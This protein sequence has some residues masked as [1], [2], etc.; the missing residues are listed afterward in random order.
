MLY[1]TT[2]NNSDT[3]T[4]QRVLSTRRA[5]DGGVFIPFHLP[6]LSQAE[7]SRMCKI[8]F[9][10]RVA[11]IL[12]L[13]FG[14]HLTGYD[15]DLAVGKRSV[16]LHQLGQRLFSAECWHNTQW[17]FL[18]MV[19]AMIPLLYSGKE[20]DAEVAGWLDTGIRMAILF[21]IFGELIRE[22]LVSGDKPAD[23]SMVSGSFSGPMAAWYARGMGLPIGNIVC[24]CNENGALWDFI[25]HGQLRTDGIAARTAVP[26][27][28]ILIPEGLEQLIALYG[29]PQEVHQYVECLHTGRTYYV[30]DGLL[31]RMRKGI[32]VTVSSEQRILSTVSSIFSAHNYLLSLPSAL[33]YAGLQ[34]YRART[35]ESRLALILTDSSPQKNREA[36]GNILGMEVPGF[37][38]YF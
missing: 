32:Y 2:R 36:I 35:G 8:S 10:A 17:E 15:V 23:L 18:G 13:L 30:D 21:G 1:T 24:C 6:V 11:E 14:V 16:R 22:G 7:I 19:K 3:F 25:C 26:E 29:G 28:D 34:D 4:A 12:N 38:T 37:E 20:E 5:P 33:A 27:A 9:N 31:D